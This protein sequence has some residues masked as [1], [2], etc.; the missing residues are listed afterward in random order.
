MISEINQ[1]AKD[2]YLYQEYKKQNNIIEKEIR[3]VLQRKVSGEGELKKCQKVQ[4]SCYK[5][6]KY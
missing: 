5:S 1:T 2:K 4:A 3:F 6:N